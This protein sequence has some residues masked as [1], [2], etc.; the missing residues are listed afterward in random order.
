[1]ALRYF[2]FTLV[3][4]DFRNRYRR[5][6]LGVAWSLARPIG[7][8]IVLYAVFWR[9][10]DKPEDPNNPNAIS[11]SYAPF[12]FTGIALWQFLTES[13][14]LGCGCFAEGGSYLRQQPVPVLIFP[15]RV[16]LSAS[17]HLIISLAIAM[18]LT[19]AFVGLPSVAVL[20]S[21]VP[22]IVLIFC[23]G[24]GLA[25]LSGLMHTHFTD[26][27]HLL[28]ILLQ[29][30][31]FLTPIIY[32]PQMMLEER[33]RMSWFVV[34]LNPLNAVLELVRQPLL[35]G[36]RGQSG[37]YADPWSWQLALM[38]LGVVSVLAW[39]GLRKLEKN[40]VFWV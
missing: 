5:S 31:Y 28:E 18:A 2:W 1:V 19:A 11:A 13:I 3:Y 40:L 7:M 37:H 17:I 10:F 39:W 23:L 22:A 16:V 26:T 9:I 15:L 21:L 12:L 6:F 35:S 38:F 4:N 33:A 14:L 27:K 36:E 8:T 32:R 25:T 24:I 29:A 34:K 20:V 30:L